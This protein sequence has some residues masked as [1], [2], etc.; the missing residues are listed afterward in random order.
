MRRLLTGY[1]VSFNRRRRRH[2]RLFQIRYKSILCQSD[3]YLLC[4]SIQRKLA[5]R[6]KC[7]TRIETIYNNYN[8]IGDRKD[9]QMIREGKKLPE[10]VQDKVPEIIEAV[11]ADPDVNALFA[12]GSL[13]TGTRKPLSD[14]D[15]GILLNNR[16]DKN[17]RFDKHIQLIGVFTDTFRTDDIDLIILNDAPNRMA[18]QILKTGKM[19]ACK[20]AAALTGF[21]ERLVKEYLDFKCMKDSFDAVFLEGIG[22]HG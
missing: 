17:Q 11:E 7:L 5:L 22:Y 20:N 14:L 10:D 2:G 16:L 1:A 9:D 4:G 6:P 8:L 13:T 12:F 19:L 18:F 3:P 21:R 15:F